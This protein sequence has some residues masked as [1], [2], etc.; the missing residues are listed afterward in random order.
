MP[1]SRQIA[2]ARLLRGENR[3]NI[4]PEEAAAMA[5][6]V[7]NRTQLHGFPDDPEQVLTQP[8]QYK[9]FD[10]QD[11]NYK[12]IMS[13]GPEDPAWQEYI[14]YA[15]DADTRTQ[16]SPYTHYF[17]GEPPSWAKALEGLTQIGS[18]WFGREKRRPK[19]RK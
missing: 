8:N 1:T 4:T 6:T 3:A 14:R 7:Y 15:E 18:H 13:F 19:V 9:P 17:T 10:P 2:I 5:D 12:V 16:R 11:P